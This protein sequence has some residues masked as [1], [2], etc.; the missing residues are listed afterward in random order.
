MQ[1][2]YVGNP[3]RII[4]QL[5]R[6]QWLMFTVGWFGWIWDAFDFFTVSLCVTEI[7]Q[8]FGVSDADVSWVSLLLVSGASTIQAFVSYQLMCRE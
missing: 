2:G 4:K 7:S 1:G 6:H 8:D 3:I 5:D